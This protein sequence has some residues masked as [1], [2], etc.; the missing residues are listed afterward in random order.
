MKHNMISIILQ[1]FSKNVIIWMMFVRMYKLYIIST[2]LYLN[3]ARFNIILVLERVLF[4]L[5]IQPM[6]V[7]VDCFSLYL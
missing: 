4:C 2:F 1:P 5:D 7:D 3:L 6:L